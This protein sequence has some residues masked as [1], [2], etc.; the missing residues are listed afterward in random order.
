MHTRTHT[1]THI[2]IYI[3]IYI[4]ITKSR[5]Q[6]RIPWLPL[7]FS[8]VGLYRPTLQTGVPNCNPSLCWAVI[9]KFLLARLSVGECDIGVQHCFSSSVS[10][11]LFV[12]LGWEVSGHIG[13]LSSGVTSRIYSVQLVTFFCNYHL[14][15]S[16]C[17]LTAS[18]CCIHR[19]ELTQL[20]LGRNLVIYIIIIIIMSCLLHGYPWPSLVTSPYHSLPLDVFRA[21]SRIFT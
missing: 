7:S 8:P 1:H 14:A 10:H 9:D 12:L 21:T 13:F 2:Y 15:F 6:H 11:V 17:V 4:Y 3:Y 5:F 20:H 16:L 18:M 19:V